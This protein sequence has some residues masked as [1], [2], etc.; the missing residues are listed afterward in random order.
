MFWLVLTWENLRCGM[1][2]G[3]HSDMAVVSHSTPLLLGSC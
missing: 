3:T 2:W 1:Y